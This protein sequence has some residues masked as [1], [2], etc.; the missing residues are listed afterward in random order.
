[1]PEFCADKSQMHIQN[2]L[3]SEKAPV[4]S[5][6]PT[7][8]HRLL[9][10]NIDEIPNS[11]DFET[12]RIHPNSPFFIASYDEEDDFMDPYASD[13]FRMFDFKVK[14]CA[15]GRSHDWTE[16]PFAHP[17]EKARR[18]DPR[19][20]H[21][22]GVVCPDFRKG[23]GC[24]RGEACEFAHGVFECWLHPA[25]YRTQPCKDGRSCTRRICFFAHT[26][27]Q[28]RVL[29][30]GMS[31]VCCCHF[32]GLSL[33]RKGPLSCNSGVS[34]SDGVKLAC[35]Y[36]ASSPTSTLSLLSPP[37]SPSLSPPLSPAEAGSSRVSPLSLYQKSAPMHIPLN[38][39]R[40]KMIAELCKSLE[41]MEF[42]EQ[43]GHGWFNSPQSFISSSSPSLSSTPP[44]V[45]FTRGSF[46]PNVIPEESEK[47]VGNISFPDLDWVDELVM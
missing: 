11:F 43:N 12:G 23:S 35:K 15:R 17:G 42:S 29:P 21:Y 36:V 46:E 22:S 19:R 28:L 32:S 7:G 9:R 38:F 10:L 41:V 39:Q 25:R 16:C 31:N 26:P 33:T 14:K 4:L 44:P 13:A 37:R 27:A 34:F 47:A 45:S 6:S 40:N 24:R 18:R 3:F 1:M 8:R 2:A 20:F 5:S 30:P